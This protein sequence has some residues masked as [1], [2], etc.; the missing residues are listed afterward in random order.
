VPYEKHTTETTEMSKSWKKKPTAIG[1]SVSKLY[2]TFCGAATNLIL[3]A[4]A[5]LDTDPLGRAHLNE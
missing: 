1:A 2:V 5:Q 4:H 3:K